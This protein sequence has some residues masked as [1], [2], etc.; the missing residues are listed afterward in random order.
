MMPEQADE[1]TIALS[2]KFEATKLRNDM[3]Y[4]PVFVVER[5][6]AAGPG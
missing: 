6:L 5:I 2:K 4:L 3:T 1:N